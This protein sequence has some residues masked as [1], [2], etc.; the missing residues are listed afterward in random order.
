MKKAKGSKR[1]LIN[2][3]LLICLLGILALG[4]LNYAKKIFP[5]SHHS[6]VI[7]YTS[8]YDLDPYLVYSIIKAESDFKED[9]IS[10]KNARGLMQIAEITGNWGSIELDMDEFHIEDLYQVDT[11]IRL[12]C[13]YLSRLYQEFG[14][15]KNT[16]IAAYNAGS[17]NVSKWLKSYKY[18]EDGVTL[19]PE[20]IP[21]P[22]TN[23]YLKKVLIF[24]K[25][26]NY[27]YPDQ[28]GIIVE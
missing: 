19:I 21:F 9:A 14:D 13:W 18:S 24:E 28:L 11:N 23:K 12:G 4:C 5:V 7:K 10:S 22:E 20:N 2:L 25:I 3:I 26:Y 16:V 1:I 6:I 27:L 15:N 8:E 17:G